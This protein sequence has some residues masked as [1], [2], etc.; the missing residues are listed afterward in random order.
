MYAQCKVEQEEDDVKITLSNGGQI[1][2]ETF[3]RM[4]GR[5]LISK[6]APPSATTSTALSIKPVAANCIGIS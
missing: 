5:I 4:P 6:H 1:V 2:I 3:E